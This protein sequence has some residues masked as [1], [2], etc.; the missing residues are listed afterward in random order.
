MIYR[1][2]INLLL[3][4]GFKSAGFNIITS[5]ICNQDVKQTTYQQMFVTV[6]AVRPPVF[7]G[8]VDASVGEISDPVRFF[9]LINALSYDVDIMH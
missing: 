2:N 3:V 5:F 4:S 8:S 6:I 1:N 7:I 9:L